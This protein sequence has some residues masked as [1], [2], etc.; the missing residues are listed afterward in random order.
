MCDAKRSGLGFKTSFG[1]N[2]ALLG[3]HVWKCIQQPDLL[4]SRVLRAR[5]F[6]GGHILEARKGNQSSFIWSSIWQAKELV[7]SGFRW[8]VGDGQS[9]IATRDAWLAGKRNFKVDELP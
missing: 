9:I 5:Y 3:K 6:P 1:F 4:V 7:V 2:V 8:V